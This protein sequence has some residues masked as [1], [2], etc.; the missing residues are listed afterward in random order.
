MLVRVVALAPGAVALVG[1]A[2]RDRLLGL[3][4]KDLDLV[5]P[6]GAEALARQLARERGGR[7][8]ALGGDRF[9]AYRVVLPASEPYTVV[10][11]W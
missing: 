1:G 7:L 8:V 11:L 6:G 9:A 5:V 3:P 10:D 4:T 2:L